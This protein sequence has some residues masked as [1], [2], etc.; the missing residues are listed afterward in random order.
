MSRKELSLIVAASENAAIGVAGD[1]PWHISADLKRFRKLTTG[2]GLIMGRK[3]F[4][5]IG[6]ILPGRKMVVVTGNKD[7]QYDGAVIVHSMDEAIQETA[8]DDQ[9]FVA[10]GAQLYSEALQYVET[11]FLTRVHATVEGDVFLPE[12]NWQKWELVD[13]ERFQADDKND[14]DYSFQLYRRKPNQLEDTDA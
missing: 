7:Y 12:I 9:P 14:H 1:L 13:S 11:I 3:T 5:S 6:R 2:H 4:E 8:D 10:G